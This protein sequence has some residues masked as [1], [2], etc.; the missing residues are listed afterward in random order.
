MSDLPPK[1]ITLLTVNP[2]EDEKKTLAKMA[3]K[4]KW[5]EAK[6]ERTNLPCDKMAVDAWMMECLQCA[7]RI[8]TAHAIRFLDERLG[9]EK[10]GVFF[11]YKDMGEAIEAHCQAKG[12]GSIYIDGDVTT[13][14]QEMIDRAANPDDMTAQVAVLSMGTCSAGVTLSP[15][16]KRLL[17]AALPW[18]PAELDQASDRIHRLGATGPCEIYYLVARGSFDEQMLRILEKKRTRNASV[19]ETELFRFDAR[20]DF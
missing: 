16:V 11:T 8:K 12:I 20:E 15:G 2:T 13:G 10:M 18:T 9:E 4:M 17:L 19:L 6:L 3:A 7:S 5:L 1:T 14:R